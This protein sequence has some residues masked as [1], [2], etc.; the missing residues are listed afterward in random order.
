MPIYPVK[1]VMQLYIDSYGA[2]FGVRNGMFWL[3]PKQHP[4]QAFAIR[5]VKCIF[6]TKGVQLSSD[7]LLLALEHSIPLIL[8]D[9]IG[10][11]LGY[12]WSG[13]YGS[14]STLRKQQA[15]FA[16]HRL[17][18]DWVQTI[19]TQRLL[20]Q[21]RNLEIIGKELAQFPEKDYWNAAYQSNLPLLK[22]QLQRWQN[23]V[24][25]KTL[26]LTDIAA[27]FRGI[28]GTASRFY[29]PCLSAALPPEW[30][31]EKRAKRPA[32]DA[33]NA[34]LNY[35]Y[36]MLYPLVELS[37]IKSG[38]DPYM[39]VLHTDRYNRPTLVY[40]CI[41]LHR[42]WAEYV[43]VTIVNSGDL[44]LSDFAEPTALEGMRLLSSGKNVVIKAM[45]DYLE[46]RELYQGQQRK[47]MTIIDLEALQLATHIRNQT[48]SSK[49]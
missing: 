15:L 2:Y 7:A 19:L 20:Y 5:K 39:G 18:M 28:E 21:L 11:S 14:V 35:L 41:E 4:G 31:F 29:Y 26:P 40:E 25:N 27:T 36:G 38:L 33:F 23:H 32:Y 12:V 37:L 49:D 17:G 1:T 44:S 24:P 47:R 6:L 9:G 8:I 13:Q 43:A 30:R 22:R 16:D 10:R 46:A 3:K 42:H 34:L 48:L 45:L